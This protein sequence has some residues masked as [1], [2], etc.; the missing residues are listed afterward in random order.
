MSLLNRQFLQ[1]IGIHLDNATYDSLAAHFEETLYQRVIEEVVVEM[2][3]EKA[4][5]LTALKDSD[6]SAVQQWLVANVPDLEEIV[7]DEIDILLGEIAESGEQ[8]VNE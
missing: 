2:T 1:D 8:L 3:P 6:E 5:E 4:E 7:S